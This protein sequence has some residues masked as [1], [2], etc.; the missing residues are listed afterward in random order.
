[1]EEFSDCLFKNGALFCD[2]SS[3]VEVGK[4]LLEFAQELIRGDM[5]GFGC[6]FWAG[7]GLG[8]LH[9]S[10]PARHKIEEPDASG[11]EWN[12]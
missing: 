7:Q 3:L 8:A 11:R 2:L 6:C 12:Q 9:H 5:K 4:A 1:M 10:K